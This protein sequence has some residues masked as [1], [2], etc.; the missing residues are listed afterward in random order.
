MVENP[1]DKRCVVQYEDNGHQFKGLQ[2]VNSQLLS[3]QLTPIT[4]YD[5]DETPRKKPNKNYVELKRNEKCFCGSNKKFKKCC[6]NKKY[7]EAQHIELI[8][9]HEF[10]LW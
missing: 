6:I 5:A 7:I 9:H 1:M 4:L 10:K 2:F 3:N 8:V